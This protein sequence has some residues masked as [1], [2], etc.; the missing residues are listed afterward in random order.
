MD[1]GGGC[2]RQMVEDRSSGWRVHVGGVAGS[3]ILAINIA[4]DQGHQISGNGFNISRYC[5]PL[6][7]AEGHSRKARI[8]ISH[9]HLT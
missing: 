9:Q 5:L 6:W 1:A 7:E 3:E 2:S 4:L 8:F